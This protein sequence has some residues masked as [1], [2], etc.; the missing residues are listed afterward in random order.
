LSLLYGAETWTI[1]YRAQVK[2]LSAFMM[3]QLRV[4]MAVKW[5]DKI[6][7]EKILGHANLLSMA[8]ILIEKN[9]QW[10]GHVHRM[11]HSLLPRQLLYSQ[12]KEGERNTGRPRLRLKDVAKRNIKW[13]AINLSSWQQT[14]DNRVAWR[15]ATKFKPN[16]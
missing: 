16:Q 3:R 8:D 10:L 6:T 9:L 13:R 12:L 11:E 15:A 7:N 1:L 2:K 14:A 5:Y 4:I